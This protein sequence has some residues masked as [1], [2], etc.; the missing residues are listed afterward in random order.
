MVYTL[1]SRI[2]PDGV[3]PLLEIF[4]RYITT[5]GNGL[6]IRMGNSIAKVQPIYSFNSLN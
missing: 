2:G 1:L 6:I 3:N 5:I 4:E